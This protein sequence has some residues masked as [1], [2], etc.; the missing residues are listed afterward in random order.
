MYNRRLLGVLSN[1][2]WVKIH[3]FLIYD[4]CK[5]VLGKISYF[6]LKLLAPNGSFCRTIFIFYSDFMVRFWCCTESH[7]LKNALFL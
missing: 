7:C 1:L 6:S 5:K 4:D 2:F 3:N